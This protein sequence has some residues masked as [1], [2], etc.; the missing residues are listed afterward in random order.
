MPGKR[1]SH[2]RAVRQTDTLFRLRGGLRI[3][4]TGLELSRRL[5]DVF[6]VHASKDQALSS[7]LA[8]VSG[9]PSEIGSV[10][11]Q[12]PTYHSTNP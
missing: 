6:F 1:S 4:V 7:R 2:A 3:A 12:F 11:E 5:S 8:A 9:G 10:S